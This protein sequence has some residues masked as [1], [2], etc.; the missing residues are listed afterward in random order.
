MLSQAE[1]ALSP[2]VRVTPPNM[3]HGHARDEWL[4]KSIRDWQL[5]LLRFA[6][7]LDMTDRQAILRKA[8]EMDRLSYRPAKSRFGFFL[9]TSVELCHA[10]GEPEHPDRSA[11]LER[12]FKMMDEGRL[13]RA[14]AAAID[15]D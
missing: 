15:L 3:L 6:V 2:H 14:M 10:I 12:Y 13:K 4:A 9:R 5:S 1:A 11:V 8:E 7:T